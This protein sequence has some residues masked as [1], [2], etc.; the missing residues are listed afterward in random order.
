MLHILFLAAIVNLLVNDNRFNDDEF[1][2][3]SYSSDITAPS[4]YS[5]MLV[6]L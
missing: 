2:K 6:D 5:L 4:S 3:P 1:I